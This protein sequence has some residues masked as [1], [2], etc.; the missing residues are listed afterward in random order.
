MHD[1]AHLISTILAR[2]RLPI[3]TLDELLHELRCEGRALTAGSLL[4]L[5]DGAGDAPRLLRPWSGPL[6]P[7]A[8]GGP[9]EAPGAARPCDIVVVGRAHAWGPDGREPGWPRVARAVLHLSREL[10]E[11][12]VLDR[13]RW[14]QIHA[15]A[16]RLAA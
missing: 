1:V 15:E 4:R 3:D 8:P 11:A 10:D 16:Q 12:S 7:L 5:L 13:A 14:L 9:D 6:A 2:R